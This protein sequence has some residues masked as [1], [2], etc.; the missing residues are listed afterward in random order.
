MKLNTRKDEDLG[1]KDLFKGI[2]I[3]LIGIT[4]V[5]FI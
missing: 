5:A 1:I 4:I 3:G 2:G